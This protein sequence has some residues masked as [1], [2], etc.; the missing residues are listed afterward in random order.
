MKPFATSRLRGSFCIRVQQDLP[1]YELEKYGKAV[2]FPRRDGSLYDYK[3][4][5]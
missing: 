4:K 5:A 2:V 3:S 1:D